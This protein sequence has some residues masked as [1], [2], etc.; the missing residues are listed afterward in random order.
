M[1]ATKFSKKSLH[2]RLASYYGPLHNRHDSHQTDICTYVKAVSWGCFKVFLITLA[3]M[4]GG[5]LVGDFLAWITAMIV[6]GMKITPNEP[7]LIV[8][9]V[10]AVVGVFAIVLLGMVGWQKFSERRR[11]ARDR[12][13][14]DGGIVEEEPPTFIEEWIRKHKEKSC[15]KVEIA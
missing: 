3:G 5:G 6:Q 7:A 9:M 11:I 14:A 15:F 1:E 13:E 10:I 2:W 8:A 12:R 4:V